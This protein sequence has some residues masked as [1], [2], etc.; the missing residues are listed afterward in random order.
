[1]LEMVERGN[2]PMSN[3]ASDDFADW[4]KFAGRGDDTQEDGASAP[5][6]SSHHYAAPASCRAASQV[7]G[8]SLRCVKDNAGPTGLFPA[9]PF[10]FWDHGRHEKYE[11]KKGDRE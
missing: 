11:K 2:E 9:G 7:N 10:S 3:G 1:M 8:Q 5:R 4:L 6:S